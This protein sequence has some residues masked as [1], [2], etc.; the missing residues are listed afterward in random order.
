VYTAGPG[1]LIGWSPVLEQRRMT[2]TAR[3]TT[4]CRLA[5]FEADRVRQLCEKDPQ[6]G[7]AFLRQLA[8][9]LS[10]RLSHTRRR[11]GGPANLRGPLGV[12]PGSSD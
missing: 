9:A 4:V 3:A 8:L 5:A 2:A 12:I 1:E 10:E 6:F 7:V 11:L